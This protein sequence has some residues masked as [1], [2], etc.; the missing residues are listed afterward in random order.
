[1]RSLAF[2]LRS[3]VCLHLYLLMLVLMF[4]PLSLS[5]LA[6]MVVFALTLAVVYVCIAFT[7]TC[8]CAYI[9]IYIC[10]WCSHVCWLL[11]LM[12][13]HVV[14]L[15]FVFTVMCEDCF[16][17]RDYSI[18]GDYIRASGCIHSKRQPWRHGMSLRIAIPTTPSPLLLDALRS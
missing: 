7:F 16:L 4:A 9:H 8:I 12:R 15:V 1:M 11:L 13:D 3:Y 14:L 2:R 10:L 18:Q 5:I 17:L 6:F